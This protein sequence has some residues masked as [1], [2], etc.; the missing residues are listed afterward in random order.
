[1]QDIGSNVVGISQQIQNPWQLMVALVVV[2][3]LFFCAFGWA[4]YKLTIRQFQSAD[5]S[6]VQMVEAEKAHAAQLDK[7]RE[8]HGTELKD[9]VRENHQVI[10]LLEKSVNGNTQ[11]I[12]R[13]TAA[14]SSQLP[15]R[16]H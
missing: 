5:A 13:L 3:I 10:Q 12:D 11:A 9:I 4:V 15:L 7:I 6:R 16:G 2:G 14:L 8:E 1:M